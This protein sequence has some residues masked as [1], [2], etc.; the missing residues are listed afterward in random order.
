[1]RIR[2]VVKA[3]CAGWHVGATHP[4]SARSSPNLQ[5]IIRSV[6]PI[7]RENRELPRST[8]TARVL[9]YRES[10]GIYT[11]AVTSLFLNLSRSVRR[12]TPSDAALSA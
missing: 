9:E 10:A 5:P 12:L 11:R 3:G 4:S 8:T 1:M 6:R 7:S 2:T